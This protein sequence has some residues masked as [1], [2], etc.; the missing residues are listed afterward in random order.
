MLC[1]SLGFVSVTALKLDC[2]VRQ[3]VLC[4]FSWPCQRTDCHRRVVAVL[5]FVQAS[6][7]PDM[8]T[9]EH[10]PVLLIFIVHL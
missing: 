10:L 5:A 8:L 1:R 6:F 2:L 3:L 4:Y 9:C 7:G